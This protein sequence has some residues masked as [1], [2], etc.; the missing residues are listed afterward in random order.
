MTK[1]ELKAVENILTESKKKCE[2]AEFHEPFIDDGG[3]ESI[4]DD[5]RIV[6]FYHNCLGAEN[7]AVTK[8]QKFFEAFADEEIFPID[9]PTIEELRKEVRDNIGRATTK[10]KLYYRLGN[11]TKNAIV[12]VRYLIDIMELLHTDKIYYAKEH[13]KN[14]LLLLKSEIGEAVLLPI[15]SRDNDERNGYWV[16]NC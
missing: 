11:D 7:I 12:N 2:I 8:T 14:S 9:L 3:F 1:K 6:R 5:Y 4:C 13:R 10:K 15:M 16:Y